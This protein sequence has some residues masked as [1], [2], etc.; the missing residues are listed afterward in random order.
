MSQQ[1]A[2]KTKKRAKKNIPVGV[3]HINATFNNIIISISDLSGNVLVWSSAGGQGFKGSRKATPYA[4]QRTADEV[5]KKAQEDYG[6]KAVNIVVK[7]PGNGRESAVR[8]LAGSGLGV[9]VIKD[10]TPVAH[11]GCKPRKRRRV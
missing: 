8:A 6:V 11:N 10:I 9:N 1:S 2:N 7:G 5:A 4:A 3:A